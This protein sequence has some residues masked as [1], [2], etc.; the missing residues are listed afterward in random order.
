MNTQRPHRDIHQIIV[1]ESDRNRKFA[2]ATVLKTEGSTPCKAG[3]KAIID[4]GGAIQGTIGGGAVEAQAQGL[5]IEAIKTGHTLV[6]DFNL[7][8]DSISDEH[9]TC[10]GMMRV[11]IDPTAASHRAV[12]AA[13]SEARQRRE[14]G[15]LLTTIRGEK[16]PGVE[17]RFLTE[18]EIPSAVGFPNAQN[19]RS[20][21]GREET[22]LLV[23]ESSPEGQRLAVL[24]EPLIP[25][26][27][28]LIMGGGHIGQALARQADLVGFDILVID[29]RKEFTA[30]ELFP[31]GATTHYGPIDVEIDRLSISG[32]TYIVIVT[33]GHRH[34]AT[35]LAACLNKPAAYIGM[36]GSRRKVRL[37]RKEFIE[38]GRTTAAEFNRVYAPI[39]LDIGAVTVPEIAN[40]I[41]AQLIA[42]RRKGA[43]PRIPGI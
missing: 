30:A 9:P 41:T 15:M 27:L 17:V 1:E 20:A 33:R 29:D 8:G 40:S 2:V 31:D 43:A 38:S 22:E 39:G 25:R 24:V 37:M 6:F 28:L 35:A 14:R 26:P 42:V 21:L 5:G 4:A 23:R 36:I 16:E 18:G 11:L 3:G 12:Y 32:D 34:D 7:E 19:I 10:G 13:A